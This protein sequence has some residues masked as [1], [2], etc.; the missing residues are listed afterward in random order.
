MERLSGK[1]ADSMDEMSR[2]MQEAVSTFIKNCKTDCKSRFLNGACTNLRTF[3]A[4][5]IKA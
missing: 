3:R 1:Y 2:R 5:I 4:R